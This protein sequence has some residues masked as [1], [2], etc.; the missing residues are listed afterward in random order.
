MRLLAL[1]VL[2][3]VFLSSCETLKGVGRDLENSG[4]ALEDVFS[5]A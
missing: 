3:A 4:E 1:L 2:A 5:G